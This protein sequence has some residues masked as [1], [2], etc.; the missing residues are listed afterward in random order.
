MLQIVCVAICDC[1]TFGPMRHCYLK[2]W[3]LQFDQ[4]SRLEICSFVTS[5]L[6]DLG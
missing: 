1:G 3:R 4:V 2:V 6:Y 5:I